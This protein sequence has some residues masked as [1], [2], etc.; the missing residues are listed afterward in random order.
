MLQMRKNYYKQQ[1]ELDADLVK[2]KRVII[3]GWPNK[4]KDLSADIKFY[5]KY[6]HELIVIEDLVYKGHKFIVPKSCRK[7]ILEKLHYSHMGISKTIAKA[8]LSF[9]WPGMTKHIQ[10]MII[11]C[12]ICQSSQKS[13]KSE[14]RI[15]HEIIKLPFYKVGC[16]IFHLYNMSYLLVTDYYSKYVEIAHLNKDLSSCNVILK[17]KIIFSRLGI[18]RIVCSDNGPEF[19]SYEFKKFSKEWDFDHV[20]SSPRYPQS[21]GHVERAVQTVKNILRKCLDD[22][23]DP[24]LALL[25]YRNTPIDGIHCAANILMNR[26]LR[27]ILP[28]VNSHFDA[29]LYQ[30]QHFDKFIDKSKQKQKVQFDRKGV[31]ELEPIKN[32]TIVLVQIGPQRVWKS[33]K[34]IEQISIRSYKIAL[35]NGSTI[36]RNRKFIKKFNYCKAE[37]SSSELKQP[38]DEVFPNTNCRQYIEVQYENSPP[39][40]NTTGDDLN[41]LQS[42]E[43]DIM[44]RRSTRIKCKPTKLK[45]YEL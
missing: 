32:N 17:L 8:N 22:K 23:K 2:L 29:K 14:P 41:Y 19:A 3:N 4:I 42:G 40:V 1:T 25:D 26:N 7:E 44:T 31:S 30:K 10:D 18:P 36:V 9:F 45:D 43:E 11:S 24:Y 6:R 39:Y 28:Q 12:Y 37:S 27:S 35:E 20:T 33:G 16:D 21:N 5:F 34:V 13:Q 15:P 38:P